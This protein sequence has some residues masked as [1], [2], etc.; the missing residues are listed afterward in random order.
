MKILLTSVVVSGFVAA[1]VAQQRQSPFVQSGAQPATPA[2]NNTAAQNTSPA[3]PGVL[4][5]PT[6]DA[7]G[8]ATLPT[9]GVNSGVTGQP[10]TNA[11]G[12]SAFNAPANGTTGTNQAGATVGTAPLFLNITPTT[13][14][15]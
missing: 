2:Q 6:G 12:G 5:N 10:L 9:T 3:N 4:T 13:V 8:N 15:D 7:A 1:A 14:T 11:T